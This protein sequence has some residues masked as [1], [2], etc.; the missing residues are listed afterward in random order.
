MDAAARRRRPFVTNRPRTVTV[1]RP[2]MV[3]T[4]PRWSPSSVACP[5]PGHRLPTIVMSRLMVVGPTQVPFTRRLGASRRGVDGRLQALVTQI[6]GRIDGQALRRLGRH[7]RC[8]GDDGHQGQHRTDRDRATQRAGQVRHQFPF[9]TLHRVGLVGAGA[10]PTALGSLSSPGTKT[11][12][13]WHIGQTDIERTRRGSANARDHRLRGRPRSS[14]K[15][16]RLCCSLRASPYSGTRPSRISRRHRAISRT[17]SSSDCATAVHSR[18]RCPAFGA[19]AC[20]RRTAPTRGVFVVG[21]RTHVPAVGLRV[22]EVV[23]GGLEIERHA[24]TRTGSPTS[25]GGGAT[26][27]NIQCAGAPASATGA[28]WL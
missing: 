11:R 16:W 12:A 3:S 2:W 22:V 28:V 19:P 8:S 7:G 13:D 21:G 9:R 5:K 17:T 4:G 14:S 26:E 25:P 15:S 6:A 18:D 24:G 23:P 20:R 10:D 27:A 1:L